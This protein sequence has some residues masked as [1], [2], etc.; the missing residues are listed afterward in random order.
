[1]TKE[2]IFELVVRHARE[3]LPELRGHAF[4]RGDELSKLGA[5]SI[6]RAEIVNFTLEALRLNV[7]RV[8]LFGVRN[9]GELVDVLHAKMSP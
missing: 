8:Q 3:V 1:M 7:P 6:D 2:D 9:I 4:Q 5:N